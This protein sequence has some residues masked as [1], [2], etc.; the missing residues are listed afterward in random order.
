MIHWGSSTVQD[1]EELARLERGDACSVIPSYRPITLWDAKLAHQLLLSRGRARYHL[2]L[3]GLLCRFVYIGWCL[4]ANMSLGRESR[5]SPGAIL[6]PSVPRTPFMA[7]GTHV[8]RAEGLSH[9][10]FDNR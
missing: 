3:F 5:D 1:A 6:M 2:A 8:E 4:G 9:Q 10:Y 7:P